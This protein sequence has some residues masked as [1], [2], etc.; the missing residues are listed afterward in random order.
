MWRLKFLNYLTVLSYDP[1]VVRTCAGWSSYA[2]THV[3]AYGPKF[4]RQRGTTETPVRI[5]N[6]KEPVLGLIDHGSEINLMSKEFY[7]RGS[8]L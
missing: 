2:L 1:L 6:I 8:G 4:S 3:S 7:R 5:G